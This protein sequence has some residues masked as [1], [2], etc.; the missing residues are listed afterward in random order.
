MN[1]A[2]HVPPADM[3]TLASK[4]IFLYNASGR[5]RSTNSNVSPPSTA[6]AIV[7]CYMFLLYMQPQLMRL[8]ISAEH[9]VLSLHLGPSFKPESQ[10]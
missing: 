6:C 4:M 2:A 3:V 10:W 7:Y 5:V 8:K 9:H 1:M